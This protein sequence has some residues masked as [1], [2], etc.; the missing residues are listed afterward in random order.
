M[1]PITI[2]ASDAL[3][4]ITIEVEVRVVHTNWVRLRLWLA[5]KICHVA[6]WVGGVG[7]KVNQQVGVI[8]TEIPGKDIYKP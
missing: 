2:D 6:V 1:T 4:N 3:K 7:L 8:V 5:V